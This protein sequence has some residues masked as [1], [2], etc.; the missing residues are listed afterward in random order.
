MPKKFDPIAYKGKKTIAVKMDHPGVCQLWDWD[1]RKGRYFPRT[2]GNR[3]YA[4]RKVGLTQSSKY[5]SS[6]EEAKR[7]R[8]SGYLVEEEEKARGLT[9]AEVKARYFEH[10]KGRVKPSS[11]ESYE[12]NVRHLGFFDAI[13]VTEITT[14]T[15][16]SWITAMKKPEYLATQHSTRI[17]YEHDLRLL[18]QILQYYGDYVDPD[19]RFQLP[20]K[21]RHN[22]DVIVDVVKYRERLDQRRS[23]FMTREENEHFLE[24]LRKRSFQSMLDRFVYLAAFIYLRTGARIGEICALNWR[25]LNLKTGAVVISKTVHFSRRKGQ[26]S[27]VSSSTKTKKT[28]EPVIQDMELLRELREFRLSSGRGE[29]LILSEDGQTPL[30]YRSIQFR[31][32]KVFKALALPFRSTHILRHSFATDFLR[33]TKNPLALQAILGHSDFRQTQEYAKLT[34]DLVKDASREYAK[35]FL[36]KPDEVAAG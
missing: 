34:D 16:D 10:L 30:E 24:E 31:M 20:I 5:L 25:D 22:T 29:G 15:V 35:S 4:Y 26:V 19:G 13:P 28:R 33:V 1:E 3:Y 12:N 2:Q 21:K 18:R 36:K 11:I 32:D 7:W 6:Y 27:Y 9:F 23:K 17:T 8:D 14:R